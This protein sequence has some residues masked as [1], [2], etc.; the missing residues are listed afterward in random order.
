MYKD[1]VLLGRKVTPQRVTLPDGRSFLA[2]NERVSRKNLPSNVTIR[3]NRT[4]GPRRQ[5]KRKTQQGAGLLGS[6]FSLGKNL[7][8]SSKRFKHWFKSN[9]F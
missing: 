9:Q 2:R 5:I 6:A 7:I 1:K 3:R 4:I 8:S